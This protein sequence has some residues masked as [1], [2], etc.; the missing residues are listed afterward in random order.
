MKE[1]HI[2]THTLPIMVI[3]QQDGKR[4]VELIE[5]YLQVPVIGRPVDKGYTVELDV[6]AVKPILAQELREMA[7]YLDAQAFEDE[8]P[9]GELFRHRDICDPH[10]ELYITEVDRNA[11]D[12]GLHFGAHNADNHC[13]VQVRLEKLDELIKVLTEWRSRRVG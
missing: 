13:V 3:A 7:D 10:D 11:P 6:D 2:G 4:P 9:K 8:H 1:S 12:T 5:S